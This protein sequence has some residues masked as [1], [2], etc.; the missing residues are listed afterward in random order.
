MATEFKLPELGENIESADII[1]VL[2]KVGEM[3]EKEQ[4]II[5]I[6]TDKATIEV[7]S[8][9]SGKIT[10]VLVNQGDSV[11]VGQTIIKVDESGK[12]EAEKAETRIEQKAE[13]KAE[14][15]SETKKEEKES[16]PKKEVKETAQS[17]PGQIVE[18]KVPDLGENIESADVINVLVKNGDM[19]AKDQGVIEIETD[20]ATVEVPSSVEG[21]IVEVI[22]KTGDKVK[23]GDVLI[24]AE[25]SATVPVKK[26]DT[27]EVKEEPAKKPAKETAEKVES[28]KGEL[29]ELKPGERDDQPPI[30]RG[31]A[32]AAPSVRRIAR[33]LGVD[34]NKVPG[35]G[36]GGRISMDDVKAYVKKIMQGKGESVGIGIKKETL[37]DFTKYGKVE[38]VAMSKIR[39]KTATHLS[40]AWAVTPHVTQ[41]DKADITQFEKSRKE[42]NSEVEKEG[43]KL[44]VT[45]ILIKIIAEGLEKFPQFNTSIDMDS[46][47]VI[48]KKYFNIGVAVDT[49]YGLLVP[50]IKNADKKNLVEISVELGQLAQKA[51]DKKLSLEEMQ[52]GCFT[53]T[54]LGGIG[55]TYFTPIVN[56]PE[57]AILGI[58]RGSFEPVYNGYGVFEPRL[59]LPVSLSYDHRI[60][61]GADAI[62]FLRWVCEALEQPL[63][64]L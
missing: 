4:S 3:I 38:R 64:I 54:N 6:E 34:I 27:S 11:K 24:K 29:L 46:K 50:V 32:P 44:T 55:G 60:I 25:S 63:K 28:S 21:K 43:G 17:G 12:S 41:F 56:S 62:R 48:Y 58:S 52:G 1:N 57:V 14:A 59:M 23:V 8:N 31:S 10:E 7:P 42:L 33:E 35:S 5:E 22:V 40:Y 37:P 45:A 18:F 26:K 61:D 30:L 9:I 47:E 53:I 39:E 13:A 16:S 49:E 36:E 20:K 15:K 19:I 2:V 51:R